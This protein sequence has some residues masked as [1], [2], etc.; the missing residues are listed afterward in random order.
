MKKKIIA[1]ATLAIALTSSSVFAQA[2]ADGKCKKDCNNKECVG[3]KC[4][5][6]K[7]DCP[8]PFEGLN[9]TDSQKEQLKALRQQD[10]Q[11]RQKC[12]ADSLK[13]EAHQKAMQNRK[14]ARVEYLAKIKAILTPEQYVQFLENSFTSQAPKGHKMMKHHKAGKKCGNG[15]GRR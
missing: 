2:P 8:N 4:D 6:R 3:K 12:N 15:G 11:C 9:L 1:L 14:Q 7:A 10:K 13:R 5:A